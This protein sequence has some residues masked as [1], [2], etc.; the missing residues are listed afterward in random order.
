MKSSPSWDADEYE[1]N[2]REETEHVTPKAKTRGKENGHKEKRDEEAAAPELPPL[3]YADITREPIPPR[4]WAVP[5]R[6]PVRNVAILSGEGSAGKS[7][8]LLQ[9]CA[10]HVLARDWIG[11]LPTPGPVIYL[12]C[13]D[14]D[15]EICRRL[16]SIAVHYRVTR[17]QIA[18]EGLH[19]LA[20]AG[21]DATLAV[22]DKSGRLRATQLF[23]QLKRDAIATKPKLIVLDTVADVFAGNENDRAQVR[24]FI[25]I[26]RGLALDA[27]TTI[28][29]AS[30]PS[31]TGINSDS[32]LSGSTAWHNSVRARM[33]L[34]SADEVDDPKLRVLVVKKN[35]YG[36]EEET[37]LLRW[38][39]G[40]YI[41]E[42]RP[43]SLERL[44]EDRKVDDLFIDLLQRFIKQNRNV[45]DKVGPSYAPAIFAQE[46]EARNAKNARIGKQA[47]ADAMSRLFASNRIHVEIYGRPSRPYR[48]LVP[49]AN[50]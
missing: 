22:A 40:V 21:R 1:R 18:E 42:P 7:I 38:R 20:Y 46:P 11:T 16:E 44:A 31:L 43:G 15:D 8:L 33:Y 5:D 30:H 10:A 35:N 49:G 27:S 26:L 6:I 19:V 34:K 25:T 37:I 4:E 28:V 36:P 3:V 32:G 29:A 48:R 12:G 17:K 23:E 45:S 50:P 2:I 39:N 13:E 41:P 24:Q 14:D 47:L 9:L